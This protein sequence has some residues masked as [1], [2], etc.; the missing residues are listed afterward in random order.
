MQIKVQNSFQTCSKR[1][2]TNPPTPCVKQLH[3]L[4]CN[5]AQQRVAIRS[6]HVHSPLCFTSTSIICSTSNRAYLMSSPFPVTI[7]FIDCAY[8]HRK[9]GLVAG[10]I[11]LTWSAL[12]RCHSNHMFS[13]CLETWQI[14]LIMSKQKNHHSN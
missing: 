8:C 13:D 4:Y 2:P 6:I 9:L 5:R 1:C 14:P 3:A 12:T 11:I 10:N 7:D